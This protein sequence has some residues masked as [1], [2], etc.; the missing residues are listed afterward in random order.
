MALGDVFHSDAIYIDMVTKAA[1]AAAIIDGEGYIGIKCSERA[2][3][4][5]SRSHK[6]YVSVSNKDKGMISFLVNNFG[7]SAE[8]DRDKGA[9]RALMHRW[10][11]SASNAVSFLEHIYPY[12]ITK[13]RQAEVAF[14]LQK[15]VNH[16]SNVLGISAE[17]LAIRD[18]CEAEIHIL[19]R[20]GR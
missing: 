18:A 15:T 1:Y 12:L 7:G 14:R 10:R 16:S 2:H 17:I 20:K 3:V 9:N 11:T 5:R 6:V 8:W 19:N 4:Q 13:K